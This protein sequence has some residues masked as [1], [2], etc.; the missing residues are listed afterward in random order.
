MVL[1]FRRDQADRALGLNG[2]V[3]ATCLE[4]RSSSNEDCELMLHHDKQREQRF[5]TPCGFEAGQ[6]G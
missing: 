1:I 5:Q 6:W 2:L 4:P 3:P